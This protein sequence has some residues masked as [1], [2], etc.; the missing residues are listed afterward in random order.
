[1]IAKQDL[2]V[3]PS[4]NTAE[5]LFVALLLR[6]L[7]YGDNDLRSLINVYCWETFFTIIDNKPLIIIILVLEINL[8]VKYKYIDTEI[9]NAN[10]DLTPNDL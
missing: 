10:N 7:S 8:P 6:I 1:V 3:I 4:T 2:A 9:I 5:S